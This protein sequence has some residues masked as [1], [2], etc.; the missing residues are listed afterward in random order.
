MEVVMSL[1]QGIRIRNYRALRDV[2][3]GSLWTDQSGAPL[4]PLTAI[5]GKNGAGKSTTMKMLATLL[6]ATMSQPMPNII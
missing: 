5:I 3:L 4:T 2:K 1:I 6:T